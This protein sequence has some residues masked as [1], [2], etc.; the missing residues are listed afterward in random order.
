MKQYIIIRTICTLCDWSVEIKQTEYSKFVQLN[1]VNN[2]IINFMFTMKNKKQGFTLIE[3]LVVIAIIGILSS[4]VLASLN[5]ARTKGKD[6][7]VKSQM[8]SVRSQA[9][10]IYDNNSQSYGTGVSSTALVPLACASAPANSL[11]GTTTVSGMVTSIN[12]SANAA[13]RCATDSTTGAYAQNWA[14]TASVGGGGF[15]CVD[16]SGAS[17]AEATDQLASTP[18]SVAAMLCQ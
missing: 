6:A 9:A 2:N 16:S 7:A 1:L 8:A 5:T 10:I 12:S 17:K 15:W 14:M 18:A 3:L 13:S 11:F 4:V